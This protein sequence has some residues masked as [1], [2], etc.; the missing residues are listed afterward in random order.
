MHDPTN[1]FY[2]I[3]QSEIIM[4]DDFVDFYNNYLK[5]HL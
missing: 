5:S 3:N 2:P 1:N 4:Y